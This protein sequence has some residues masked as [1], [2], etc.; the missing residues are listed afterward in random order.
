MKILFAADVSF[1]YIPE[2]CGD[3]KAVSAFS[4]VAE[5]FQN[6]DFSMVNL[7]NILGNREDY[8]PIEKCGPNLIAEDSFIKYIE[9]LNPS[10]V[11]LANNHTYDYGEKAMLHTMDLLRSRGYQICGAGENIDE[12][13]RPAVFQ[14]DGVKVYVIAVC[15]NEFG[16]AKKNLSGAAGYNLTRVKNAIKSAISEGA[17][18][19]VYFHGGNEK[20]PFPS[21]GKKELYRHFI[22]MGA[23]AVI[24]M[25]TH[26]PQGYEVYDGAPI[27]Y[28]MGNFYFPTPSASDLMPS[29]SIGYMTKLDI[30]EDGI[31]FEIIPYRFD[32]DGLYLLKGA[33]KENFMKYIGELCNP[34]G[35]D[36]KLQEYF[37]AWCAIYGIGGYLN[38]IAFKAEMVS[39]TSCACLKNLL[40]CEAHNEL[41]QNSIKIVFERRCEEA[42]KYIPHIKNMQNIKL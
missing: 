8:E 42:K 2:Y 12:A 33:E 29:W 35:D 15:E 17:K 27:I 39:G 16:T 31:S 7:E 14:K 21:P 19:I 3:E 25:H 9:T 13:Y 41:I 5:E 1:N 6:A 24:A 34:I 38:F 4:E 11:G 10:A 20:N 30:S 23:S 36:G 22:D 37:D 18:P 40:S 28:S 32:I 26:C